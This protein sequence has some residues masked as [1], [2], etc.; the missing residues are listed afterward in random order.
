I[1]PPIPRSSVSPLLLIRDSL[2]SNIF[3]EDG[4]KLKNLNGVLINTFEGLEAEALH[5]LNGG[6]VTFN[7]GFGLPPVFPVGPFV[8]CEFEKLQGDDDRDQLRNWLDDQ[9]DGS[10]VNVSFGS[11][12]ALSGDQIREVGDGLVKSGFRFLWVVK[13][14]LVEPEEEEEGNL[15]IGHDLV[16]KLKGRGLVV[17]SWVEQGEILG[18]RAVGGFVSH[19]GWNSVVEAAWHGVRVL[20]WPQQSDQKINAEVCGLGF[21]AKTWPWGGGENDKVVVNGEEIGDKIKELMQSEALRVQAARIEQ[22]AKK[23][24]EVGGCRGKMLKRLIDEWR[25]N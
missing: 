3:L 20:A 2:F 14:K 8:P 16:E 15:V 6:K 17:K 1:C 9:H 25:K 18:H 4:P 5:A 10:V 23:T 22:E 21:W 11:R 19:C 7:D 12:T 24:A 13:E